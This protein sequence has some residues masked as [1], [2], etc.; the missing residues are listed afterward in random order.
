MKNIQLFESFNGIEDKPRLT[1]SMV[2][3]LNEQ[4]KNELDSSQIYRAISCW[5]DDKGLVNACKYYFKSASEELSHMEKIYQYLFD[6]NCKAITPICNESKSTYK[7]ITEVV[8][9]SLDHEMQV[10]KNWNDIADQSL[11]E[12]DNDT[13]CLS[14]WFLKEQISEENKFRDII[15][16]IRLE[17]PA[18]KIEEFF[19][20]YTAM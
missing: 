14:Q 12:K 6:K 10:T 13:Y 8:Q 11:K 17:M 19:G 20:T 16:N 7:D 15:F 5:C 4:I 3:I 18:W 1:E 2:K 9:S